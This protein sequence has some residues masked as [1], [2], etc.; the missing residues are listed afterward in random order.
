MEYEIYHA[1]VKGMRWG[2][3]RYQNADGSLTPEGKKRYY[4]EADAAGYKQEGY[5]GRRYKSGK[6]GKVETY[7]ANPNKWAMDDLGSGRKIADEGS[8]MA[9]KLKKMNDDG[10][11][12]RKV[13]PMDLSKM[14]DKEMRDQINRAMLEKQYND[15]F[16]PQNEARGR[17]Q[18]SRVLEVAGGVLG[19]GASAIGITLGIMELKEKLGK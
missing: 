3:R 17:E 10:M 9:N 7:D 1:G 19:V 12:N 8:T 11:R 6:G 16:N 5:G 4:Q 18:V 13:E 14:S 2:V 15:M